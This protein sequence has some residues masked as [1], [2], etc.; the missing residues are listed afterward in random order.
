MKKILL[1]S[2]IG[3]FWVAA[4]AQN[5][6]IGTLTPTKGRL[7][8]VGAA[9][10]GNTNAVFGTSSSGISLQQNWPT[11]GFNQYRD[12]TA[13]NGKFMSSGYAAIQFMDPGSGTMVIDMLGTGAANAVTA[14]GTRA[15]T[16]LSNGHVGINNA[17]SSA[18]LTVSRGTGID[19]TALFQ[20]TTYW[21]HFNYGPTEN[22]Y[23][24]GG[25]NDGTVFINDLT[26][27]KII[28]GSGAAKVGINAS[29]PTATLE[30][31]QVT[32]RGISLI[33]SNSDE[34]ELF[35]GLP[36]FFKFNSTARSFIDWTDGRYAQLSDERLKKNISCIPDIMEKVMQLKPVS[37]DMKAAK[38]GKEKNIGFIAQEVHKLFPELVFILPNSPS[39]GYDSIKD[40]HMMD[41]SGFGVLA[42]KAI[43]EQQT[44]ISKLQTTVLGIVEEMR[45]VRAE[46]KKLLQLLHQ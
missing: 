39:L 21:S 15:L 37:Y 10:I 11:I 41:Y 6:G 22:T 23:I 19:G 45:E 44:T 18:T 43:Q 27:G 30:I 34:W 8:V 38:S 17:G 5:V 35:N 14:S 24:R 13:G 3:S 12:N 20:G 2:C 32:D 33:N 9:G 28:M 7:E 36:L 26:G 46:N 16:L 40:L 1:F 29:I 31:I 42:I 25:K 4:R